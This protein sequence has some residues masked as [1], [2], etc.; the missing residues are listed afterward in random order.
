MPTTKLTYGTI[1][2]ISDQGKEAVEK[3][4]AAVFHPDIPMVQT[5]AEVWQQDKWYDH[6]QVHH[7][8]TRNTQEEANAAAREILEFQRKR[9]HDIDIYQANDAEGNTQF[10]EETDEEDEGHTNFTRRTSL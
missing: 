4:I 7:T 5:S 3:T 2:E 6:L 8:I 9:G 1:R 10:S